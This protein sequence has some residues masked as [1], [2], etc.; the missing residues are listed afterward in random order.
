M[1]DERSPTAILKAIL[2]L[3]RRKEYSDAQKQRDMVMITSELQRLPKDSL[4]VVKAQLIHSTKE[5]RS[6]KLTVRMLT[7][8]EFVQSEVKGGGRLNDS[9]IEALTFT[10]TLLYK[11]LILDFQIDETVAAFA[12]LQ[13]NFKGVDHVMDYI[14][15][16]FEHANGRWILQHPFVGYDPA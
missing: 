5:M 14:F 8:T 15:E 1:T 3:A 12:C 6:L 10:Q 2:K 16:Q 11:Q 7:Q 9:L 13:T 4:T